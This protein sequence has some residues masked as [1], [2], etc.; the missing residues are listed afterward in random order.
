MKWRQKKYYIVRIGNI[1]LAVQGRWEVMFASLNTELEG[2]TSFMGSG[3]PLKNEVILL[4]DLQNRSPKVEAFLH[5]WVLGEGMTQEY[6][7]L[8]FIGKD[9][10]L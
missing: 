5:R 4:I 2:W 9:F 7:T 3:E 6:S 1:S 8:H 10:Q